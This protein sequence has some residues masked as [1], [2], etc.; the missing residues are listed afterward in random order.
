MEGGGLG[1][2]VFLRRW[3]RDHHIR[4]KFF[5]P[6]E[7]VRDRLECSKW[8]PELDIATLDEMV[9][10]LASADRRYALL[11]DTIDSKVPCRAAFVG[12]CRNTRERPHRNRASA[13]PVY[14]ALM[15]S[16]RYF[17]R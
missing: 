4:F 16:L 10:L 8:I 13:A 6:T 3:A 2:L 15:K 7:S 17:S 9:A 1:M 5:N 12:S 11:P 14:A